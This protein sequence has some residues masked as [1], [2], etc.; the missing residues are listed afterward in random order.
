MRAKK[1]T[2]KKLR[3]FIPLESILDFSNHI[4]NMADQAKYHK[5][6]KV[7]DMRTNSNEQVKGIYIY[8]NG[9]VGTFD[10]DEHGAY[11][12]IN[13]KKVK[14]EASEATVEVTPNQPELSSAEDDDA[15]F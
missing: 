12:T 3:L 14:I 9:K 2:Q 11:G 5:D 1:N 15:P 10:E 4:M 7:W 13:P 6:G 8:G